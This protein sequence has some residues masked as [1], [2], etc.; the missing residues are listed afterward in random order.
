MSSVLKTLVRKSQLLLKCLHSS[1]ESIEAGP[2][3]VELIIGW[4]WKSVSLS[5]LSHCRD[6][7]LLRFMLCFK[8]TKF[9]YLGSF[10]NKETKTLLLRLLKEFCIGITGLGRHRCF[11]NNFSSE[12]D[13]LYKIK[14]YKV[15]K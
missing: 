13:N 4:K 3:P 8:T 7:F 12:R 11:L 1:Q 5:D 15:N 2:M 6:L 9:H 14:V 10:Q